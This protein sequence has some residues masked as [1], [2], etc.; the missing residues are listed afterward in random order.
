VKAYAANAFWAASCL[1]AWRRFQQSANHVEETQAKLLQSYLRINKETEYGR[2]YQFAQIASPSQFQKNVP[3]TTYDDYSEYIQRIG[4]GEECVLTSE[5]VRM[6]ELSSGSTAASKLIPYTSTLKAEF[7]RGIAPWIYN[8]YMNLPELQRGPAYWSVTPLMDGK[9]RTPA[10]IPIGFESDGAYLGPVGKWL[11]DSVMAV[12]NDVKNILDMDSFRYVTL[13]CLLRQPSLRL[14]SVWN[15]TFLNLLLEPLSAWWDMLLLDIAHGTVSKGDVEFRFTPDPKRASALRAFSP[16]DVASLW[17]DLRLIS[18]W[19]DGASA[20][21]AHQL[22]EL[23]PQASLQA[24]GL[25]ATEAFVSLPILGVEGSV[26]SINSHFFEFVDGAGDVHLA[27]QIQK[28]KTYSVV[29]TT[30]GGFYRYQ[31]HDIVEVVGHW[32]QSPCIRFIG[33]ADHI[34]DWFGEKLEERFVARMLQDVFAKHEVSPSF[35]M[36]APEAG[37]DFRYLLYLENERFVEKLDEDL[38]LALRGNFHY[39]YCRKLGQLQAAEVLYVVEGAETYL[40]ACQARG[41]KLGNVKPN[42]LQTT[43]GWRDCFVTQPAPNTGNTCTP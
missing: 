35:A 11:A 10:G 39:D 12:P 7:Q 1:P 31:L 33:K 9:Q 41:Q 14:I 24:K 36:L 6:F 42:V 32:G 4:E 28:G 15:P 5:R 30:G 18:C 20:S 27:D 16:T 38:D 34:S 19:A 37:N 25:L 22:E 43:T 23:F 2:K 26:L 8:L 29:I 13:S 21:Y 17:P 40:K 3:L